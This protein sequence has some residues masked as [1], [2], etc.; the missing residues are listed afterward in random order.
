MMNQ[1]NMENERK[2]FRRFMEEFRKDEQKIIYQNNEFN[3]RYD[4]RQNRQSQRSRAWR[5][6]EHNNQD[7]RGNQNNN[8]LEDGYN[9]NRNNTY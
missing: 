3:R 1:L 2:R 9:G 8:G 4:Y 6:Q 5:N 7:H